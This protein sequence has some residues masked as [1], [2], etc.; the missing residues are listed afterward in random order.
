MT[1]SSVA[2]L[3]LCLAMLVFFPGCL[4]SQ[5]DTELAT[6]NDENSSSINEPTTTLPPDAKGEATADEEDSRLVP[7]KALAVGDPAPPL[8]VGNWLKGDAVSSFEPGMVYV[9]EFWATWCGPCLASMPHL[10]EL[11][12]KYAG[13]VRL[14]GISDEDAERIERFFGQEQDAKSGRTWEQTI[15]YTIATDTARGYMSANYMVAAGQQGIPTAFVVGKDGLI[16]WIGH[17]QQIDEPLEQIVHDTWDRDAAA[18]AFRSTQI[19]DQMMQ[20]LSVAIQEARDS[21]DWQAVTKMLEDAV[22]Q[23]ANRADVE[24]VRLDVLVRADDFSEFNSIAENVAQAKWE[25]GFPLNEIAW[26]MVTSVPAKHR[27]YDAALRI[28]LRANELH[29]GKHASTIDTVARVHYERGDLAEAIAWQQKAIAADPHN[30]S[31]QETLRQYQAEQEAKQA[32]E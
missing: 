17:P 12:D 30:R 10:S 23:G 20:P 26:K 14:I 4:G 11:Q 2:P 25:N 5:S 3:A 9:V 1:R 6:P 7:T 18:Q 13:H 21:G 8:T 31:L 28:A 32:V 24:M 16:E 19:I 15:T 22:A 27:D 29:H